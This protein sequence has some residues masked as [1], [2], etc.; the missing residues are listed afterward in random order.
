MDIQGTPWSLTRAVHT[1]E[2]NWEKQERY[3]I[4]IDTELENIN[5]ERIEVPNTDKIYYIINQK[6]GAGQSM[7]YNIIMS[8]TINK[9]KSQRY[10]SGF[11]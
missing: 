1:D 9:T 4:R 10:V 7:L 11:T 8:S 6:F 2:L 5:K 3:R